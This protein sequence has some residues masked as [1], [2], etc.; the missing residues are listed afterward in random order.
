MREM[1]LAW[2]H[3]FLKKQ[4]LLVAKI[5]LITVIDRRKNFYS[6]LNSLFHSQSCLLGIKMT[7]KQALYVTEVGFTQQAEMAQI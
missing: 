1:S 4:E 6:N 3:M 2:F 5:N 7:Q